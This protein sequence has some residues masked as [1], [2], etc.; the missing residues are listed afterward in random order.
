MDHSQ[1][2]AAKIALAVLAA[3]GFI[4]AGG[5]ALIEHGITD[6]PSEDIDLF[7]LH[8]RHTPATF[9]ASV[10]KMTAAL[11]ASGYTVEI[12]RQFDEF[13]SVT[14]GHD[15]EAIVIDLGLDWWENSPAIIDI[16]PILSLNDSVASKL[17]AVYGRGYAR[18]YLDAYS[19][20]TSR[21]FTHQQLIRLC[22]RRDPNLDLDLFATSITRHRTLPTTEFTKYGLPPREL[23]TLSSTLLD[24]AET[25]H[26]TTQNPSTANDTIDFIMPG[27]AG[28]GPG[29][30]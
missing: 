19:I 4:L 26:K 10:Q 5:Q 16:G 11:E 9:A 15:E 13:A 30:L 8:R 20:I 7:A 24:F 14:V 21:R 3:D 18:D 28:P 6:R 12:T 2:V 17:L 1:R 23:P 22:Q 25:I 29:L 27:N